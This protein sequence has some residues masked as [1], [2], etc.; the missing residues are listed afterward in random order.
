MATS[1]APKRRRRRWPIALLLVFAI[2]SVAFAVLFTRAPLPLGAPRGFD[3]NLVRAIARAD[4]A[5]LPTSVGRWVVGRAHYPRAVVGASWDFA[6]SITMVFA[7]FQIAWPDH[8]IVVDAPHERST[9]DDR[10]GGED[11]DQAAF[12]GVSEALR[13]ADQILFTHEHLDHVRGASRSPHW[14][15]LVPRVRLT[16]Q[17]LEHM[18]ADA[19]FEAEQLAALEAAPLTEPTRVA[20]G[21]VLIPAPGHTPGSLFVYIALASGQEVLLVGDAVWSHHNLNR[22]VGRPLA[23]SLALHEDRETTLAQAR[24]LITLRDAQPTLAVVPAHDDLT[25]QSYVQGGFLLEGFAT[26][27]AAPAAAPAPDAPDAATDAPVPEAPADALDARAPV[28]DTP[29]AP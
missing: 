28:V 18:P 16:Q 8:Y 23:L 22:A 21:V 14:N 15:E 27:Q 11:Y 3:L 17:Q 10:F 13:H 29:T 5:P 25:V 24:G 1:P 26:V 19:G 12:D 9:H 20:P 6:T 4:P 2:L 7:A